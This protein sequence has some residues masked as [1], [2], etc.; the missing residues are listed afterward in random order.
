MRNKGI[1]ALEIRQDATDKYMAYVLFSR[2]LL[3]PADEMRRWLDNRLDN[4]VWLVCLYVSNR[5]SWSDADHTVGQR[6][7]PGIEVVMVQADA[8]LVLL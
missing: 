6:L 3:N 7:N 2:L 8:T 5:T 4:S 1:K